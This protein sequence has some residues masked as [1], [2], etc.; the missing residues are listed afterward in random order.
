[1]WRILIVHL[2]Y[3]QQF[4]NCCSSNQVNSLGSSGHHIDHNC[5]FCDGCSGWM[6]GHNQEPG[7]LWSVL[8]CLG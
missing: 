4:S 3:T 1:M 2:Y 7:L 8:W 5:V 6:D